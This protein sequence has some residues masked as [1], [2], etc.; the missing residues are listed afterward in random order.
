[1]LMIRMLRSA[2]LLLLLAVSASSFA[3]HLL[4]HRFADVSLQVVSRREAFGLVT[5]TAMI[6][7]APAMANAGAADVPTKEDL[8]RIRVGH[9]QV[10][11]LLN[12]FDK[13]TTGKMKT[14]G[15]DRK[16]FIRDNDDCKL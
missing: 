1:M 16:W 10:V 7:G 15:T 5:A 14:D 13:E 11:Y 9:D 3:P 8:D 4:K 2:P 6:A 12:N